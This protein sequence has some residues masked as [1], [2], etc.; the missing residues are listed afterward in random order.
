MI[1]GRLWYVLI[2]PWI[3]SLIVIQLT[4][5]YFATLRQ[6][7]G[8][9]EERVKLAKNARVNDLLEYLQERHTDLAPAIPYTLVSINRE[10][11][12]PDAVLHDGDEVAL[13]P[14]VSGGAM[15]KDETLIR[16]TKEAFDLNQILTEMN[17][18]SCEAVCVLT[19][20]ADERSVTGIDPK[21]ISRNNDSRDSTVES[22]MQHVAVEI[23]KQWPAVRGI[24]IARRMGSMKAGAPNVLIACSTDRGEADIY[25]A[26]RFGL[27]LLTQVTADQAGD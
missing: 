3:W 26:A 9:R 23:R 22:F 10:Y 16:I 12:S 24:A 11:G 13:Y 14:P 19:A 2:L 25:H 6:R 27:D 21:E 1:P 15:P 17:S 8:I 20:V 4:V 5:L 7:V 18:P